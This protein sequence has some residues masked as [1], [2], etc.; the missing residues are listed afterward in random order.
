M[1]HEA[2][3]VMI[4]LDDTL[5]DYSG[6]KAKALANDPSNPYPQSA[7]G[8]Y[9]ELKPL[10][11]AQ[12]FIEALLQS[13]RIFPAICTAPSVLNP[14]SYTEKRYSVEK[15]FGMTMCERLYIAPDKGRILADVLVDDKISGFGQERF[16]GKLM[17][18]GTDEYQNLSMIK[19][20]LLEMCA[21]SK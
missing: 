20:A 15:L 19:D 3:T 6:A 11:Y 9:Q 21:G 8:F 7:Y 1:K 10:P 5:L 2:L 18:V 12:E 13:K 17:Q 16:T 14:M 4:D